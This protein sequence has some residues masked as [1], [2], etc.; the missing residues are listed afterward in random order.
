MSIMRDPPPVVKR[1]FGNVSLVV[2][3]L[4]ITPNW[5]SPGED[6]LAFRRLCDD[7]ETRRGYDADLNNSDVFAAVN[8]G[9]I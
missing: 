4:E 6:R 5:H 3:T 1:D 2:I 9:A 8:F 7:W